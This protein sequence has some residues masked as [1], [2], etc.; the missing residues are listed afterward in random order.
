VDSRYFCLYEVDLLRLGILC[1]SLQF[2]LLFFSIGPETEDD[3]MSVCM[4]VC[5]DG[6]CILMKY[7]RLL[8]RPP[9]H[10]YAQKWISHINMLLAMMLE[11]EQAERLLT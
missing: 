2:T 10:V 4:H 8:S 3:R 11:K 6:V 5:M 7:A 1:I 9:A